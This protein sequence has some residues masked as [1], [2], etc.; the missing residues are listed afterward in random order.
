MKL[1][2]EEFFIR[3]SPY[4]SIIPIL[5]KV[6]CMTMVELN[7]HIENVA[8]C[9]QMIS[10]DLSHGV[11]YSHEGVRDTTGVDS[12]KHSTTEAPQ[13]SKKE[14]VPPVCLPKVVQSFENIIDSS[15]SSVEPQEDDSKRYDIVSE[16]PASQST[17]LSSFLINEVGLGL[18]PTFVKEYKNL[19]LKHAGRDE[20]HSLLSQEHSAKAVESVYTSQAVMIPHKNLYAIVADPSLKREYAWGKVNVEDELQND[21][22]VLKKLL[23]EEGKVNYYHG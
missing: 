13:V 3:L 21:F 7:S 1:V 14:A 8:D 15:H 22:I 16:E 17:P 5:A 10:T 18:I 4:A 9:L 2:D 20:Q 23:F 6:D 12:V 19:E 11:V